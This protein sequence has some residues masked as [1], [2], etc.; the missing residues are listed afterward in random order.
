MTEKAKE[1]TFEDVLIRYLP[2][3]NKTSLSLWYR[4]RD[5]TVFQMRCYNSL[6]RAVRRY[7]NRK[8]SIDALVK[9]SIWNARSNVLKKNQVP[10]E[11][12]D[13]IDKR[14]YGEERRELPDD[15][16][17]VDD[18]FLVSERITFLAEGD[19][20]RVFILKAW[21]EGFYEES[22]LAMFL[23]EQFGGT[24]SGQRKF[25]Q[26]FRKECREKLRQTA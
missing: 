13:P 9:K 5:E 24:N 18:S 14:D 2:E 22:K 19:S 4:V 20:R 16:A 10:W 25:I 3:I 21:S 17:V 15:L 11:E 1:L 7:S 12:F 6:E 8:G 26:R 23:A